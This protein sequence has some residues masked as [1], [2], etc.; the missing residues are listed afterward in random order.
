MVLRTSFFVVLATLCVDIYNAFQPALVTRH[1]H[2]KT[3]L[4][5]TPS[6]RLLST[7]PSTNVVE[8][9]DDTFFLRASHQAA[10][11]RYEMLTSGEDPFG[12]FGG[13]TEHGNDAGAND[14][15]KVVESTVIAEENEDKQP[16][17]INNDEN[18][19]VKGISDLQY[20]DLLSTISSSLDS[21]MSTNDAAPN[22]DKAGYNFHKRLMEARFSMK[23][24]KNILPIDP[25][26]VEAMRSERKARLD[27]TESTIKDYSTPS[28]VATTEAINA[29]RGPGCIRKVEEAPSIA[30]TTYRNRDEL[31]SSLHLEVSDTQENVEALTE[32][33]FSVPSTPP[34]AKSI[35][36]EIFDKEDKNA[37][38]PT[39]P[40]ND[41]NDLET[42]EVQDENVAMGLLVLTRSFF[43]LKQIV[44]S[45]KEHV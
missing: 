20:S 36:D 37:S 41:N 25:N 5:R 3:S 22:N 42:S 18:D 39:D 24:D 11:E 17:A 10:K 4:A 16:V 1:R 30:K 40:E 27:A 28:S 9:E 35:E 15:T 23:D 31:L 45:R 26:T 38:L 34:S 8:E 32:K 14:V 7:E 12:L 44:D 19:E 43:A 29:S 21:D 2:Q 13:S 33:D 6:P